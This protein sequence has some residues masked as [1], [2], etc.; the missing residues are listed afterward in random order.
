[1]KLFGNYLDG[2]KSIVDDSDSLQVRSFSNYTDQ[3]INLPR[4]F[5]K[6][7]NESLSLS[8]K[9]NVDN[10]V[11][12]NFESDQLT[13]LFGINEHSFHKI[14]IGNHPDFSDL[15]HSEYE[16]HFCVSMFMDIK[17]ST[18]LIEKFSLLQI[19]KIKDTVL[20]L[21]I[22][23]ATHFGGHIHRLQGDAIF[24]QFVRKNQKDQNAV[25]NA[26]NAASVLT[27]FISTDLADIFTQ[28]Q[29]IPLRVRIGIDYGNSQDV[30]W[31]HYGV[32]GCSELTTTSLHTDLAAKLQ[33]KAT[34]NG[35]LV[36]GNIKDILDIKSEFCKNVL[37]T[38]GT[39]DYYI[40]Q[41]A[42]NYRKFIFD[43]EKYLMSFDFI[44]KA[45]TGNRLLMEVPTIRLV[46]SINRPGSSDSETYHQ[47]SKAIPKS[48]SISFRI[49]EGGRDYFKK[50]W[51][52]IEWRAFN[53]G[54]EA[55]EKVQET[56][57]F[58]GKYNNKIYCVT[59]AAFTGHHF[60]ECIIKRQH[61]NNIKITFPI[62]VE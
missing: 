4:Y 49:H 46:C 20:T 41:G 10:K 40:Y 55:K 42:K 24:V 15:Q 34:S 16:N 5:K 7:L 11:L 2:I 3:D 35:I 18:R 58:D 37:F 13:T 61:S 62:F 26:L 29:L 21:A 54:K 33:A 47:N 53:S 59:T 38:D 6:G 9:A 39:I 60:V 12:I 48:S 19:R 1:M 31:S 25:I 50:T 52:T 56:H 32:P 22:N 14:S 17:G 57:T 8:R 27:H 28:L 23:V 44:K 36:G 45:S 43:W 30:I 51:E